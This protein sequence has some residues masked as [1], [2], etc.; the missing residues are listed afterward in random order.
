M[1]GCG[2]TVWADCVSL[3]CLLCGCIGMK[4]LKFDR[5]FEEWSFLKQ[6][7]RNFRPNNTPTE[8]DKKR[9]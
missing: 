7:Y 9:Q 6:C 8:G 1:G 4:I 2:G 5:L 3:P